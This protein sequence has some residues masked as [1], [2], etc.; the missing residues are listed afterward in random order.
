MKPLRYEIIVSVF[1]AVRVG[2][3]CVFAALVLPFIHLVAESPPPQIVL[4]LDRNGS[5]RW[6]NS[7]PPNYSVQW[8]SSVTGPWTNFQSLTSLDAVFSTSKVVEVKVPAYFR[9]KA[10]SPTNSLEGVYLY[11]GYDAGTNLIVLGWFSLFPHPTRSDIHVGTR[12]LGYVG[13]FPVGDVHNMIGPQLGEH[14]IVAAFDETFVAN[15][16]VDIGNSIVALRGSWE[17]GKLVGTWSW[18]YFSEVR[19]NGFF[20]A[21]LIG[22]CP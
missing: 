2:T 12:H 21:E 3:I 13:P 22:R 5:L 17:N 9:V 7:V 6:S 18:T 16:S 8:S 1:S 14:A 10:E 11:R 4:D 15:L 20:S 19:T